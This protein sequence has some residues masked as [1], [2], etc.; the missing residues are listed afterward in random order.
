MNEFFNWN[1]T[2]ILW[3]YQWFWLLFA[4]VIGLVIGYR[5]NTWKIS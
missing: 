4:F 2:L 5:F 1:D 3:Q